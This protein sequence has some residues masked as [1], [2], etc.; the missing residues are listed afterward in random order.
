MEKSS[1][2]SKQNKLSRKNIEKVEKNLFNVLKMKGCSFYR[3]TI[4]D[5]VKRKDSDTISM[6]FF[7]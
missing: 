1:A 3:Q 7:K 2:K 6:R 5:K 4:T